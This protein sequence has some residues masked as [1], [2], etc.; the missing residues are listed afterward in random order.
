MVL[1]VPE[2]SWIHGPGHCH[3]WAPEATPSEE[4][5]I[6]PFV[7]LHESGLELAHVSSLAHLSRNWEKALL[8]DACSPLP[9]RL[10]QVRLNLDFSPVLLPQLSPL[11]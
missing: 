11:G 5:M 10:W 4:N 6:P 7:L 9:R 8:P 2:G 1:D 3:F